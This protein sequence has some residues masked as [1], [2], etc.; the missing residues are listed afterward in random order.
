[1]PV[2][3]QAYTEAALETASEP[4]TGPWTPWINHLYKR[5]YAQQISIRE[6]L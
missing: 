4:A 5:Q 3:R 2:S 6:V 1:M